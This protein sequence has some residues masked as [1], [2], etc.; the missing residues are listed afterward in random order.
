M[1]GKCDDICYLDADLVYSFNDQY[2]CMHPF[3]VVKIAI[4]MHREKKEM[5][6]L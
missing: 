1:K 5:R 2:I 6:T 3:Y 4:I